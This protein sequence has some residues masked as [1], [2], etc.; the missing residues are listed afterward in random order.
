VPTPFSVVQ[1]AIAT[2]VAFFLI[3]LLI[4]LVFRGV[5]FVE[6]MSSLMLVCIVF[7]LNGG[8]DAYAGRPVPV[9]H[10][11]GIEA[12]FFSVTDV[13]ARASGTVRENG[14]GSIDLFR[15]DRLL[16]SNGT[17]ISARA[18]TVIVGWAVDV[19][20]T[21]TAVAVCPVLDGKLAAIGREYYGVSRPDV[22]RSLQNGAIESSGFAIEL[23]PGTLPRGLHTI[24]VATLSRNGT[25]QRIGR[26]TS[27]R[28]V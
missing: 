1:I 17:S 2:L 26:P 19:V 10:A 8:K 24:G 3:R 4:R 20:T 14:F 15:A 12:N 27:V 16:V 6:V 25:W 9:L 23:R 5:R 22:A 7:A 11:T 28:V 18:R 13:C 21:R